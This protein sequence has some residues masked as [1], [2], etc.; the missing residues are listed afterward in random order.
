LAPARRSP[1][2]LCLSPPGIEL[3]LW[4]QHFFGCLSFR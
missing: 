2:G 4:L 3:R 1:R